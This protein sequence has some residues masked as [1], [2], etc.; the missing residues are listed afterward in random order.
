MI[1]F[2]FLGSTSLRLPWADAKGR[3]L[4][5]SAASQAGRPSLRSGLGLASQLREPTR[6]AYGFA[7]V[8]L[9][10]PRS[11]QPLL[12]SGLWSARE[13]DGP[14]VPSRLIAGEPPPASRLYAAEPGRLTRTSPRSAAVSAGILFV[15]PA[16]AG[17]RGH[18]VAFL[19]YSRKATNPR[20]VSPSIFTVA[21]R[22]HS[23]GA[24]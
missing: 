10:D 14:A 9:R 18:R 22:C 12:R 17:I 11:P 21:E 19:C 16:K 24:A 2:Y 20:A 4:S 6:F 3:A 8:S 5:C 15:I 1:C 13:V 23:D 7:W